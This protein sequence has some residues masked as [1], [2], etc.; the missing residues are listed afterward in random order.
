MLITESGMCST[1]LGSKNRL[2]SAY[3]NEKHKLDPEII[4]KLGSGQDSG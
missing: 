4:L 3:I 2:V 1:R